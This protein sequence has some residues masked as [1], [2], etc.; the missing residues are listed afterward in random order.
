VPRYYFV[1]QRADQKNKYDPHGM[2][3]PNDTEALRHAERTIA[4]L[5]KEKG[6]VPE[7]FVI[8]RNEKNEAILAVPFLPACA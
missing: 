8:V 6:F 5:Q 1:V 7:G 3:L 4:E 2:S